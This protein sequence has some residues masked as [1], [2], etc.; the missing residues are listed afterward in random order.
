MVKKDWSRAILL[1]GSL[2]FV[3]RLLGS[4]WRH[5]FPIAFPDSTTYLSASALGP[6]TTEFWFGDKP[7]GLP[8]VLWILRSNVR[9]FIIFQT[10]T[11]IGSS[12]FLFRTILETFTHRISAWIG[13]LISA[14]VLSHYKFAMWNL[15]V[16]SESLILSLIILGVAVA[17]RLSQ[18]PTKNNLALLTVI[19]CFL[20][21]L[22]DINIV[23]AVFALIG[24]GIL[25]K[26]QQFKEHQGLILRLA[27]VIT[28]TC[29]YV[30]VA[31]SESHRYQYGIINNVGVRVLPD[32]RFSNELFDGNEELL[33]LIE[34]RAGRTA[35][36]DGEAFL[37]DPKLEPF[38]DW[39]HQS[40]RNKL[41][42]SLISEPE[43]WKSHIT[44]GIHSTIKQD[45][46]S[47][48]RFGSSIRLNIFPVGKFLPTSSGNFLLL[49]ASAFLAFVF[50]FRRH[51][52]QP[53]ATVLACII[54]VAVFFFVISVAAD[55]VEVER[56]S[57]PPLLMT[58][59]PLV[60]CI[61]ALTDR[62]ISTFRSGA[63]TFI[64]LKAP[65]ST[66]I[67]ISGL[68][69]LS[70]MSVIALEFRTQD[71]DPSFARTII[72][73]VDRFGGTYYQ[74][75][76]WHHGPLDA[77]LYDI[78][79]FLTSFNTYWF[80]IALVV[81]AMSGLV[82]Y[83][84]ICIS[85]FLE[86]PQS[87]GLTLGVAIFLHL[88]IS[89][90]DYAGVIYSRNTTTT[91]LVC[92]FAFGVA[93][94]PWESPKVANRSFIIAYI[95]LGLAVQT[96]VSSIITAVVIGAFIYILHRHDVTVVRPIIWG[97]T[98]FVVAIA[99]APVWYAIRGSFTEFWANWWVMARHMNS[100]TNR[101]LKSQISLGWDTFYAYY[102]QRPLLL[103]I[104]A[105]F[106]FL[107]LRN[108]NSMNRARKI[109][110]G[111]V[112]IWF[113]AAWGELI[114]SQRYSSHYFVIPTI[115][116]SIMLVI[117]IS[118]VIPKT[119][120]LNSLLVRIPSAIPALLTASILIV[121]QCS[122]LFWSGAEGLSRF[123][124]FRQHQQFVSDTRS[125]ESK[126]VRAVLDLVSSDNDAIL[127]WTMFPWTYLEHQR[128]PATRL[129]WKSFMLGEIYLASTDEKYILPDTWKW[130]A[131]DMKQSRPN[132]FLHPKEIAYVEG[133]PFASYVSENF[134]QA[135]ETEKHRILIQKKL[136][137][138]M[139]TPTT[140]NDAVGDRQRITAG[141]S[142]LPL[143]SQQ[144]TRTD[145]AISADSSAVADSVD[146]NFAQNSKNAPQSLIRIDSDKIQALVNGYMQ[147][148][149]PLMPSSNRAL[150]LSI[151]IGTRS[152]AVVLNGQI[153]SAIRL[154]NPTGVSISSGQGT[155]SVG[156]I[157]T[158][159]APYLNGCS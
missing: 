131:D 104:I 56:H 37:T 99:S 157:M 102:T 96:M 135:M 57:I 36:D 82:A 110:S 68:F 119:G 15:E 40:G 85:K 26:R 52:L 1:S 51:R 109:T 123:Q 2:F 87:M 143:S 145:V 90:S 32:S 118:S 45:L 3:V 41:F 30:L 154:Q 148:S 4:G 117:V 142:S 33:H 78:P 29:V 147:Y 156:P 140:T 73:R 63:E 61:T 13:I 88:S 62:T 153:V 5:G 34:G 95:A 42:Q 53:I 137:A 126:T 47:Y 18:T 72:E 93:Q 108:W 28:F 76:I 80:G 71:W 70:A 67:A 58:I 86:M 38:R 141:E 59:I 27:A 94:W 144:C 79:R 49:A 139:T 83:S 11:Y 54:G 50:L 25:Y 92:V 101:N 89:S 105:V 12:L 24:S 23:A 21:I 127:A 35:W 150:S 14:G 66:D 20:V 129:S 106:V 6:F 60:I 48:D 22:R 46:K 128:V 16:L 103:F 121:M 8:L 124:S 10:I 81:I 112:L 149:Q 39:V 133:T 77:L 69:I 132:A 43:F 44:T 146:L 107:L 136:W 130:F 152:A 84:I 155:A 91:I 64:R 114:I 111:S 97:S 113:I 65:L 74:N 134:D 120:V 19:I 116:T 138:Q 7:V 122:D 159:R 55:A 17:I 31:Q 125:G 115:P 100:A 9:A 151:L 98:S 158:S 75:G